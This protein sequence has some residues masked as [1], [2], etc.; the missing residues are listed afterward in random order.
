V[1]II[2]N[3]I[4]GLYDIEN[5]V[6]RLIPDARTVVGHGQMPPEKLEQSIIDFAAH[7]YDVLIATTI[8]ESGIDMPQM[9]TPS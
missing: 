5:T 8:V 6:H 3:R 9:S 2:N 7:D 1:F 4:E